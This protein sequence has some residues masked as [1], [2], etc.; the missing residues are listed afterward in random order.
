MFA[1]FLIGLF[2]LWMKSTNRDMPKLKI[3]R[4]Q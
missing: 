4:I 2:M 1:F 3:P